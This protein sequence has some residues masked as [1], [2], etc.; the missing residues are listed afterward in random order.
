MEALTIP[1]EDVMALPLSERQAW[2][3]AEV[4]LHM[5]RKAFGEDSEQ[6][7]LCEAFHWSVFEELTCTDL[8]LARIARKGSITLATPV[9]L[10]KK[11]W[12]L[13]TRRAG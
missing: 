12:R 6:V 13:L 10:H 9:P 1:R 8:M 3:T 11:V 2:L 4:A 5:A 7:R